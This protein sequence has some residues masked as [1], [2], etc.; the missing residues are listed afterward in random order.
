MEADVGPTG[1]FALSFACAV[2]P[3]GRDDARR[4]NPFAPGQNGRELSKKP[5]GD[6]RGEFQQQKMTPSFL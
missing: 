3:L 2:P 6:D 4:R 1:L 5:H